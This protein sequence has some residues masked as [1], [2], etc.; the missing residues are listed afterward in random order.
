MVQERYILQ[1]KKHLQ[2][3]SYGHKTSTNLTETCLQ[4]PAHGSDEEKGLVS[5]EDFLAFFNTHDSC[6]TFSAEEICLLSKK[7]GLAYPLKVFKPTFTEKGNSKLFLFPSLIANRTKRFFQEKHQAIE[8]SRK[9]V[10]LQYTFDHTTKSSGSYQDLVMAFTEN[11]LWNGRGG[12]ILNTFNQKVE[13]RKLGITG[14]FHGVLRWSA[15]NDEDSD[16]LFEFLMLHKLMKREENS[17]TG[18]V[19]FQQ[20]RAEVY[21]KS[22]GG[23]G[24]SQSAIT[25]LGNIDS[26]VEF[27]PDSL[28]I[29]REFEPADCNK[30]EELEK[31]P[32]CMEDSFTEPVFTECAHMICWPCLHAVRLNNIFKCPM[33]RQPYETV[34][35]VN[36]K[37]NFEHHFY[38]YH[39]IF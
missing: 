5:F 17:V 2:I 3:F 12:K 32:I 23:T 27:L 30:E 15:N 33:C 19:A 29:H 18:S 6:H 31:C 28:P 22:W 16:E 35:S 25:V 24:S 11:F 1:S 39:I 37:G 9:R 36:T 7:L 34:T 38:C 10:F 8:K 26:C 21:L 20:S 13:E 14:G 4:E